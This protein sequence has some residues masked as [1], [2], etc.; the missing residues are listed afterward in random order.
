MPALLTKRTLSLPTNAPGY[1]PPFV[2]LLAYA[3]YPRIAGGAWDTRPD[4]IARDKNHEKQTK[5]KNCHNAPLA[6]PSRRWLVHPNPCV[7]L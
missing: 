1:H 6:K 4:N 5:D 3:E 7:L 2:P